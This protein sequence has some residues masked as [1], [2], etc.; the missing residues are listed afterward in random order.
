MKKNE[1]GSLP[2]TIYKNDLD[3]YD[4]YLKELR[5]GSEGDLCKP[6][7]ITALITRRKQPKE[8]VVTIWHSSFTS[9]YTCSICQFPIFSLFS[10]ANL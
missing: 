1:V 7:V 2:H 5:A 8:C 4:I 10:L 3:M 6:M 9:I